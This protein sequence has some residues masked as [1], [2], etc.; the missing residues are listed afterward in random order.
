MSKLNQISVGIRES[1]LSRAQT[2]ILLKQLINAADNMSIESFSIKTIKTK[3][4]IHNVHRLDQIGGK[5][6]FIKE[7][8][9]N[10]INSS[11]DVG[12]HSMKDVP[13]EDSF[14]DLEIICWLERENHRDAL[15]S[16]SGQKFFDLPPGAII[17]TS[18]IR[19]R[20]QILSL[21]KDLRIKLLRGNVDTRIKKLRENNYDAIIL[22]LAG[23]KRLGLTDH[24]TEELNEEQFPPAASQGTVGVQSKRGSILKKLFGLI[25]HHKTEIESLTEREVLKKINANCNSPIS[26]YAKI[27]DNMISLKC[28]IYDHEGNKLFSNKIFDEKNQYERLANNLAKLILDDIGQEKIDKLDELD[29]FD[30]AP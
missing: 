30:Y 5:G 21:R 11:V 15:I 27:T 25:N 1:K 9:K 19:R 26:V 3:G 20:A 16:N 18:S 23:L 13:A 17:G 10:I 7:I 24:V 8:E 14:N 29:D 28:D 12:I 22:S 2:D 4:D 6:L